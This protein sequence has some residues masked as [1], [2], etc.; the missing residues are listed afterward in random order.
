MRMLIAG[1]TG[2]VGSSLIPV[3]LDRD[4]QITVLS[5]SEEKIQKKF[6]DKVKSADW[7]MLDT[8]NPQDFDIVMNLAGENIGDNRWSDAQKQKI[9][10]SRIKTTD[11][12]VKFCLQS[13]HPGLRFLSTSAVGIYGLQPTSQDGMPKKLHEESPIGQDAVFLSEVGRKWEAALKPLEQIVP[14]TIMRFGVVIKRHEGFLK[15]LEL[16][17]QFGLSAVLGTG[18]QVLS[19]IDIDDLINAIIFLLEHPEITGPVNLCA[20]VAVPQRQFAKAMATTLNRPCFLTLPSWFVEMVFGQMG[21]ELLLSGQNVYPERLL[22]EG[23]EFTY[24]TIEQSL[25]KAFAKK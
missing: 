6:H 5:R 24:P 23:F 2:L 22:D 14:V 20:P 13:P 16:P 3:L 7:G 11:K 4:E 10:Q 25:R 19:W 9:L 1:G 21:T 8:L 18:Q 12:L 17:A 15:K